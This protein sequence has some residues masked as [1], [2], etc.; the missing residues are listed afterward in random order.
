MAAAE[1]PATF[2]LHCHYHKEAQ[3]CPLGCNSMLWPPTD[4]LSEIP[5]SL[6][7]SWSTTAGNMLCCWADPMLCMA[8]LQ[9]K[10][11]EM[12]NAFE[13]NFSWKKKS[14]QDSR[15]ESSHTNIWE[16]HR[17]PGKVYK[18]WLWGMEGFGD[19]PPAEEQQGTSEK[20]SSLLHHVTRLWKSWDLSSLCSRRSHNTS[21]FHTQH[22]R[23]IL[24]Q[25]RC[26]CCVVF[27]DQQKTEA[28]LRRKKKKKE[29][30]V[31]ES[32]FWTVFLILVGIKYFVLKK[33]KK[34]W[35]CTNQSLL[36]RS[37]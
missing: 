13:R 23:L 37:I 1:Y 29:R 16:S 11:Q 33:K 14:F 36:K 15:L 5:A 12:D 35:N 25:K 32:T 24:H 30:K 9:T 18:K 20:W 17:F 27:N 19:L 6:R 4:P 21:V 7:Y 10:G 22:R 26:L 8:A 34:D 31:F 2:I 28:A 3:A